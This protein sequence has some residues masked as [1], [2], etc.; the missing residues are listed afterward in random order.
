MEPL[1]F[2]SVPPLGKTV[3]CTYTLDD[4]TFVNHGV[5][6]HVN[7]MTGDWESEA[8]VVIVSA[9]Q[10]DNEDEM[11]TLVAHDDN[12]M[13]QWLHDSLNAVEVQPE[14]VE[15][16]DD[17]MMFEQRGDVFCYSLHLNVTP[18]GAIV[19]G[20]DEE[21][22]MLMDGAYKNIG[23]KALEP[24]FYLIDIEGS[25]LFED[26]S[27]GD[28]INVSWGGL[29]ATYI[30]SSRVGKIEDDI[31]YSPHGKVIVQNMEDVNF[32]RDI[33]YMDMDE[34]GIGEDIIFDAEP[35]DLEDVAIGEPI[36][37]SSRLGDIALARIGTVCHI[38][39]GTF[40]TKDMDVL[41]M[42]GEHADVFLT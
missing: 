31:L 27:E 29:E 21:A 34:E 1:E 15:A 22:I 12:R 38:D 6:H 4:T 35:V 17:I 23:E 25:V 42:R 32:T 19:E 24:K 30:V 14:H 13:V 20:Q 37:V 3:T 7:H 5:V 8:G 39:N 18:F 10:A 41:Y 33:Y 16:G 9:Q 26:I 36:T 11:F 28:Y 40:Y 2:S